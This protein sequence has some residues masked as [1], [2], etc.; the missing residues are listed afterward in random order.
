VIPNTT[1]KAGVEEQIHRGPTERK[2]RERK[3]SLKQEEP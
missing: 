1:E 3:I 2:H